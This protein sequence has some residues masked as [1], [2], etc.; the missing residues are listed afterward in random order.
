M[1]TAARR[2]PFGWRP[3]ELIRDGAIG[4]VKNADV[5]VGRPRKTE[6]YHKA[7]SPV[8]DHIDWDLWLGPSP[9]HDYNPG[10]LGSCLTRGINVW[11]HYYVRCINGE[12]RLWVNGEEASGG[13]GCKPATGY[14][15]L[16]S[17]GSPIDFRNL[18][19]RELP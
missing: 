2:R 5:W 14:L 19:I 3:V 17:E 16:E 18:R 11:N 1:A 15:C 10:Y 13:T 9:F 6:A 7:V 12:V 8:P 4:T